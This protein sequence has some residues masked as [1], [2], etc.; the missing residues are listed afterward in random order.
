MVYD[1][2]LDYDELEEDRNIALRKQEKN[3]NDLSSEITV[4][5]LFMASHEL[6]K[7][8][9]M[10][11]LKIV[12]N[13]R[14]RY[15]VGTQMDGEEGPW[16][17]SP[18]GY[19]ESNMVGMCMDLLR[20]C[21]FGFD[22]LTRSTTSTLDKGAWVSMEKIIDRQGQSMFHESLTQ[23]QLSEYMVYDDWETDTELS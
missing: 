12:V 1:P 18:K 15:E 6:F 17:F 13:Q 20:D 8:I 21:G 14:M 23:G 19:M 16:T 4:L 5:L 22:D 2:T 7:H 11:E 9:N 3:N 10:D